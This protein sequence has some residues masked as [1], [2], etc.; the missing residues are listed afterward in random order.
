LRAT[1]ANL[2]FALLYL[3]LSHGRT[4][5]CLAEVLDRRAIVSH[6]PFHPAT[7][8]TAPPPGT[9]SLPYLG[10]RAPLFYDFDHF[11]D[12]ASIFFST[13]TTSGKI[14]ASPVF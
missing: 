14:D 4:L 13:T 8:R 9:S 1:W 6:L 5:L 10:Y 12:P 3:S 2:I 11:L 7:K